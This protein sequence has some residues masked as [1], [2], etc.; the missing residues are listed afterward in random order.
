MIHVPGSPSG[1]RKSDT[2]RTTAK[3]KTSMWSGNSGSGLEEIGD[4]TGNLG[5]TRAVQLFSAITWRVDA[6]QRTHSP[7]A[8]C[9][10]A[11]C[12]VGQRDTVREY[13]GQEPMCAHSRAGPR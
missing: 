10:H 7:L 13:T 6:P 4:H 2:N 9:N 3:S 11:P 12:N 5:H 1:I 8:Q